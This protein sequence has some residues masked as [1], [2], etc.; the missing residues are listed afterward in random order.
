MTETPE[1]PTKTT[2]SIELLLSSVALG[3]ELHFE[4]G[5]CGAWS[6]QAKQPEKVGFHV[7]SQGECWFGVTGNEHSKQRLQAGDVVFVNQ[8]V[9]HF[10]SQHALPT[11]M[12]LQQLAQHCIAEHDQQG[13]V[14]YE[15]Q[16]QGESNQL[17]FQLLPPWLVVPAGQQTEQLAQLLQMV[18]TETQQR[19]PGYR[20][21]L[22]RLSE[23][24]AVQLLRQVIQTTHH[25][26]GLFAALQDRALAPV[27]AAILA[28]PGHDWS[29]EAMAEQAHLSV[30]AFAERCVKTTALSPK[31]LLDAI[32]LQRAKYLLRSSTLA[33][34]SI[35]WAIGYQSVT[36]F[37]R[38]F[39]RYL[40]CTAQAFREQ[41]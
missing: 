26:P 18:R 35:A 36:A 16:D 39:K 17:V 38:F 37:G 14:C 10:L 29:V 34:E 9:S 8:G 7:L 11:D 1:Q 40:G 3:T 22:Q 31:K 21:V 33:V 28:N 12:D 23:I 32:R 13:I 25:S 2:E 27:V 20:T 6:I 24:L 5:L 41:R 15:L 4:S 19:K 30:S